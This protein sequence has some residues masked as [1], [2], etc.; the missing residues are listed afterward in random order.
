M[1]KPLALGIALILGGLSYG[2]DASAAAPACDRACLTALITQYVDAL[3]AHDPAKLTVGPKVRYTEDS[4][5]A[6][7]GEGLWKSVTGKTAFRQDY[8][9]TARQVAAAHVE[10][11]EG[12]RPVLYSVVLHVEDRKIAGIETLVQ[13]VAADSRLK[14]TE[15]ARPIRGMGDPVP[16]G[17]RQSREAMVKTALLYP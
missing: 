3:V 1:N 17:K 13:R 10:L 11:R 7:L 9:D 4:K 8:I 16:A 12:D 14:P 15:L 6:K 2:G 5:T